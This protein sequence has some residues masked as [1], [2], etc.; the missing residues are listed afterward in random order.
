MDKGTEKLQTDLRFAAAFLKAHEEVKANE[1]ERQKRMYEKAVIAAENRRRKK[2]EE[3][4]YFENLRKNPIEPSEEIKAIL[5][6]NCGIDLDAEQLEMT[7]AAFEEYIIDTADSDV[8]MAMGVK[9][10]LARY[11]R[12]RLEYLDTYVVHDVKL[13]LDERLEVGMTAA[14]TATMVDDVIVEDKVSYSR[15][16]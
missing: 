7:V 5:R 1:A 11:M 4:A 14:L 13:S 2:E 3:A 15:R 10:A 8:N 9:T 6:K 12:E 16:G